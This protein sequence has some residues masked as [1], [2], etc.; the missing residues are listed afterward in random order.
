[1]RKLSY[2]K[3]SIL[4]FFLILVL[5][6][7]C[8]QT[9]Y[10]TLYNNLDHL[11]LYK[12]S[13]FINLN[14][15]QKGILER[16]ISAHHNWHRTKALSRL[17]PVIKKVQTAVSTG[18]TEAKEREIFELINAEIR[19]I[20]NHASDDAAAFCSTITDDQIA[21]LKE[22]CEEYVNDIEK[23]QIRSREKEISHRLDNLVKQ[24]EM[25]Y[26]DFSSSQKD[27]IRN[28]LYSAPKQQ[29]IRASYLRVTQAKFIQLLESKADKNTLKT[30]IT[31][32]FTR[33]EHFIPKE[34]RS[35]MAAQ[36]K[37]SKRIRILIDKTIVTK[38]Q[39]D[40]G[41]KKLDDLIE[42]IR[43]LISQQP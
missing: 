34:F 35:I 19:I 1:M 3:K 16:T 15:E 9:V 8:T 24:L 12:I 32:W 28:L 33:D 37:E 36:Q 26:G 10:R 30:Y 29:N 43:T 18:I 41:V 6:V 25:F 27:E 20:I 7:S 39:R 2:K 13:S 22:K 17:I 4:L 38:E 42:T 21:Y 11:L 31:G 14:A 5:P 40:E 23:E